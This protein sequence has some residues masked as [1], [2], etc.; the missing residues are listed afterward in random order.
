MDKNTW[1][2]FLLIAVI[3]VGFSFI[4]RPSKEELAERQRIQD[5]IALAQQQEREMQFISDQINAQL[6]ADSV[7]K[8]QSEKDSATLAQELEAKVQATYGAFAP[9]A[10]GQ[11]TQ[12]VIE[13]SKVRLYVDSKGGRIARAE[14]KDY[15][16]YGDTLNDLCLFRADESKLS[17]TLITANNRILQT[18]NLFF[19]PNWLNDST[20]AMRLHTD[21]TEAYIDFVYTVPADEYMIGFQIVP[22]NMQG[23]LAQNINSLEMHWEQLIPQQERGRKFEERYSQLQYM[24]ADGSMETLSEAKHDS[25]KESTKVRWI[26]YKDQFFS[27]VMI[28]DDAFTSTVLESTPQDKHSGYLKA[29]KTSTSVAFDLTGQKTTDFR[30]YFGPNHYNTLKAYDKGV[31]KADRLHLKEL[32]P[33]GWKVVSW[34]N[35]ILVIP[36]FDLF[37]S[38]GLHIGLVIVLMT[39]VIKLIILPFVFASYKSSAKMRVLKPQIDAINEKYPPEKMQERQQ[40]TMALYQKA[41]VSPMSGCLPMLFQFPVVMAMFWFFPTAIELRGKSLWW[42]DDLSTYDAVLSW[43]V[44][45]PLIGDHLSIFCLMFTLVN[46]AYTYI[47]MQTQNTDP[48]MKFMKWMMY[49]MPLIFFFTFNDYAAGLSYYY[50]VSLLMTILQTYIFRW[51]IDDKKVL[52]QMEKNAKKRE[53]KKKS[54][55]MERLEQM[56]REQVRMAR[57][58]AKAQQKKMR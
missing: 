37:T 2:G 27:T 43:G 18:A 30:F 33:L 9:A 57:E 38:W 16:A 47:T 12:T 1:I 28:A 4:G 7:A 53:G 32:V 17:Y 26:G 19:E 21:D 52:E 50:C 46:V 58:N 51:A 36:M 54:G 15:K 10:K 40:A 41:G 24:L 3:I 31:E 48:S 5:S 11:H 35:M 13:N 56:Q 34:I 25:Q 45:L 49:L 55:F 42:A 23:V 14:L 29:Y 39:L 8:I 22:H 6:Y 44:N 20:L